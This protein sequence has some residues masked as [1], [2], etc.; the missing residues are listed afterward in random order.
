MA[1]APRPDVAAVPTPE[2][3]TL[4]ECM[5]SFV[6]LERGPMAEATRYL[7]TIAGA[8]ANLAVGL[9]RLGR[10]VAYIGRVG[11]DGLGT[12]IVRGLRGEGVSVLGLRED[13][14]APTGIMI[15]E[16]RD[17]GPSE[18]TYRRA[19]SAGSRLG[20]EDLWAT[21]AL[22]DGA[23]WLHVTGITPALSPTAAAA[24][25]AA[26]ERARGVGVGVSFDV[27]LR[28][29]LWSD[30]EARPVLVG[31]AR[32]ARVVFG[33]LDELA[34]IAGSAADAE[35]ADVAAEALELGPERV[36]VKLGADGAIEASRGREGPIVTRSPAYVVPR[37][38]DPVG[39]GDAFCA[40]YIAASLDDRPTD[41]TLAWANACGAAAAA[42]LAELERLLDAGGPDTLR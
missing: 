6:A 8:E 35:P 30:A 38:V 11:A 7:R 34:L 20:P 28:R 5:A 1:D 15:R 9:A 36:V 21:G 3:V 41:E 39:A 2:V 37:V 4:G 26:V 12:A 42:T 18:V 16:L 27:N 32:R 25:D 24:V 19:G 17:L 33:S 29:R 13:P 31:I 40:G 14:V 22:I 10:R 23:R